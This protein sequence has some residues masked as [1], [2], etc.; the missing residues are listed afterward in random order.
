MPAYT[1]PNA[2]YMQLNSAES[3]Q[4]T[5]D[6]MRAGWHFCPEWDYLLTNNNDPEG[7][8]CG[9][10]PWRE[11]EIQKVAAEIGKAMEGG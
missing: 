8:S 4:L 10:Q 1:M 3:G 6:E 9:C 11:S 2:R 5:P 7:E